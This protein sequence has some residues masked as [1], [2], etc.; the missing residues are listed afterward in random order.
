MQKSAKQLT[1]KE[2]LSLVANYCSREERCTSDII[3]KLK[4]FNLP[5]DESEEIID[6][7]SKE[8]YFDDLRYSKAFVSDKFRFNKWGKIKIGYALKMKHIAGETI[9]E[10]LESIDNEQYIQ[11]LAD[12]LR[13]KKRTLPKL[14]GYELNGKLYQFAAGRGFESDEFKKALKMINE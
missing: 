9:D 4:E 13:K 6:F 14:S 10:A 2:I 7:L 3:S 8:K 1:K 11:L 5:Q 12:E